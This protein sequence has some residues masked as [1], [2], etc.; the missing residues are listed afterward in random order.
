MLYHR[1]ATSIGI[2]SI[3]FMKR[4][5]ILKWFLDTEIVCCYLDLEQ[6]KKEFIVVKQLTI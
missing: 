6:I 3:A 2:P 4:N 1:G 5:K